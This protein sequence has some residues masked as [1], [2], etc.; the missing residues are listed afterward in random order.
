[1]G[2]NAQEMGRCCVEDPLVSVFCLIQLA[3]CVFFGLIG[4]YCALHVKSSDVGFY[5]K[6]SEM[7]HLFFCTT[8]F[9]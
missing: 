1:M 6:S 2:G 7:A 9:L 8:S 3:M 4:L 5:C